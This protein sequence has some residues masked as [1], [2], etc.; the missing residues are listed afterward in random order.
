[1]NWLDYKTGRSK[2][3]LSNDVK[4]LSA[5]GKQLDTSLFP[6]FGFMLSRLSGA[7]AAGS[8]LA[9]FQLCR[10]L[11]QRLE[12]FIFSWI[13]A[14]GGCWI[15]QGGSA[16]SIDAEPVDCRR[17]DLQAQDILTY[18]SSSPQ[19]VA[20]RWTQPDKCWV[21]ALK[22]NNQNKLDWAQLYW[23]ILSSA[24]PIHP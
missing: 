19:D 2:N 22:R 18:P 17:L 3:W 8:L 16:F 12:D 4:I 23:E 13:R 6:R 21:G 15:G 10:S 11:S 24:A 5:V 9:Q 14:L 7:L 20:P 1:M